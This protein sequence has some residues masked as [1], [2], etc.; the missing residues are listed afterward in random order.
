M[1]REELLAPIISSVRKG[2]ALSR[3]EIERR[4]R[5]WDL[6]PLMSRGEHIGTIA[7]RGTE[8]HVALKEGYRPASSCRGTVRE[9]LAPLFD[10]YGFLTTRLQYSHRKE[11]AFIERV[12]FKATWRDDQFE[13]YMLGTMPF[14]RK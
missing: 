2:T 3:F 14:E 8:V 6:T 7:S 12:G 1:T 5:A 9:A 10:R 4:M 11:K 13:F